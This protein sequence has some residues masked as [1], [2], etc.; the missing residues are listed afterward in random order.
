V[1]K[2]KEGLSH[3]NPIFINL[4]SNTMK[5]TMQKYGKFSIYANYRAKNMFYSIKCAIFDTSMCH[6]AQKERS[7]RKK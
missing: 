7:L 2:K 6:L 1:A 5:N 3:D 4:K